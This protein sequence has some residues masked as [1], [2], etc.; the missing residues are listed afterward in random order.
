[1]NEQPF[2]NLTEQNIKRTT[3]RLLKAYYKNFGLEGDE[4]IIQPNE[5]DVAADSMAL[6]DK[7]SFHFIKSGLDFVGEGGIIV[8]GFISFPKENGEIFLATFEATSYLQ[9]KELFYQPLP[10]ILFWDSLAAA[11][12]LSVVI[13]VT[14]HINKLFFL[15]YF[16]TFLSVFFGLAVFGGIFLIYYNIFKY[17]TF[18]RYRYIYAIEQF[19]R[20]Y[21]Q[22]QWV[23]FSE[24]VF[25]D[26]TSNYFVELKRQCVK[27]GV[28][29]IKVD[30][31]LN[32]QFLY[33]ASRD[34]SLIKDRPHLRLIKNPGNN[35]TP[36]APQ[37]KP[38]GKIF[39]KLQAWFPKNKK[40]DLLR[41][42]HIPYNQFL[43][44]AFSF[45]VILT[46][47]VIQWYNGPIKYVNEKAYEA[48]VTKKIKKLNRE[49]VYY[50]ID[51]PTKPGVFDT[52]GLH[53]SDYIVRKLEREVEGNIVTPDSKLA[54]A[55]KGI[56]MADEET[57]NMLFYDCERFANNLGKFYLVTDTIVPSF[58][59][60]IE[61]I[62]YLKH[63]GLRATALWR[64][65]LLGFD[66]S[67]ILYLDDI[68][69]DSLE[70]ASLR[71]YYWKMDI[72]GKLGLHPKVTVFIGN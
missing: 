12:L 34:T 47:L 5:E 22:D 39:S 57:N 20:Y 2:S 70:A 9:R 27:N 72:G 26:L 62:N 69:T 49:S 54:K 35:K 40:I 37:N 71:D 38:K 59:V 48:R 19:K 13:F 29:L 1:M 17:F 60:A 6:Y 30:R 31:Y 43:V 45:L 18:S 42:E 21:A 46:F 11:S 32:C 55:D 56:I 66:D 16:G 36:V 52:S 24:D 7:S 8:D 53:D 51:T 63:A 23:A 67:Y 33:A 44:T 58:D 65:C 15:Y 3:L 61:R 28:G 25:P 64:G 41:F 4:L 50:I 10:Q 14:A 68:L